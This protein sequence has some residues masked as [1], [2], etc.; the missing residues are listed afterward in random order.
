MTPIAGSVLDHVRPV[1][2]F[3]RQSRSPASWCSTVSLFVLAI[4]ALPAWSAAQAPTPAA[5]T[6]T[7]A[8]SQATAEEDD[9]AVLDPAE[10]DF[11]V[12]NL[13]STLRLPL[14]KGNF[15][16]T[17]RFAGNL[18]N[19]D[20]GELAGTLFG[21]DQGAI[22]G[23]EYRVAVM[24]HLQ[25]AAYRSSFDRTIEL[26]AKYDG[27]R[28]RGAMPVS[29]SALVS[30]EGTN[31]FQEEYAP[32][33]GAVFSRTVARRVAMY[34]SP[35]WVKNTAISLDPLNHSHDGGA[36]DLPYEPHDHRST[37]YV[38]LGTR[39][40][41][42][43]TVYVVGEITPRLDGYAPDQMEY[44]FGVEKRVGNHM[45]SLT[46]TNTFGTTFSQLARGGTANSLYLGFNL[47]RKFF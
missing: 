43:S 46:F 38:G 33:V 20:F 22:I 14:H 32:A 3:H 42:L 17:H 39:L 36:G 35:M 28:Q 2:A 19:R 29:V 1:R 40:R 34:A 10:P 30:I 47:A 31:N 7:P 9:D 5:A 16:L 27:I 18:R 23:F 8:A 4:V 45:F 37:F 12:V 21:I 13:P 24:R 6:P 44:G 25:A 15:R 41:L 11:V 26:Y